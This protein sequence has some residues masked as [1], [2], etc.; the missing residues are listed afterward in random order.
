MPEL[1]TKLKEA[2]ISV[3]VLGISDLKLETKLIERLAR[4]TGGKTYFP[5]TTAEMEAA[6]ALIAGDMRKPS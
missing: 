5:L 6:A 3:F 1:L 2:K 4:E